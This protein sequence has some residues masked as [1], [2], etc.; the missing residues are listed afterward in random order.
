MTILKT[1]IIFTVFII[2]NILVCCNEVT[3]GVNH[4]QLFRKEIGDQVRIID[5]DIKAHQF[6]EEDAMQR[7]VGD[8][9][10]QQPWIHLA[11]NEKININA[12]EPVA[13]ARVLRGKITEPLS[14]R[15]DLRRKGRAQSEREHD[16]IF[17][18]SPKRSLEELESTLLSV[19]DP[20]SPSYG[21]HMTKHEVGLLTENKVGRDYVAQHLKTIGATVI[22][23]TRFGEYIHAR[24]PVHVWETLLD[25]KFYVY[26]QK[27]V[28]RRKRNKNTK[29]S[30]RHVKTGETQKVNLPET[31]KETLQKPTKE[32]LR[33]DHYSLPAGLHAHVK[34]VLNT[35]QLPL[36]VYAD[37]GPVLIPQQDNLKFKLDP[38]G[39]VTP[40]A[41]STISGYITPAKLNEIYSIGNNTGSGAVSQGVYASL[42]QYFSPSDLSTF[43]TYFG[44][45]KQS[46]K[47]SIGDHS[48]SSVCSSSPDSCAEGNLDVQ[49]MTAVAQSTPMTYWYT[50]DWMYNWIFDVGDATSPPK[51]LSISYGSVEPHVDLM[52]AFN[53][54]ALKLGLQGVTLVASSGDDGA[55][56]SSEYPCNYV[57]DYPA[58]SPYVTAVG[59]TQVLPTFIS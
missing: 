49:Y 48:S 3:L 15:G 57:P 56:A 24:A 41:Y 37:Q 27:P 46:V 54:E 7:R 39:E 59:A 5:I 40:A 19:S 47:T 6:A 52:A 12:L 26:E 2:R 8:S 21:D 10:H 22:K 33:C 30:I 53:T 34:F 14:T 28:Q 11:S 50:D 51:V 38:N 25:T 13:A 23:E 31:T 29:R 44:L 45:P 18:I 58:S 20:S 16:L 9:Q 43:Q 35:V 4:Q 1:L 36:P 42:S 55:L 32:T 17:A